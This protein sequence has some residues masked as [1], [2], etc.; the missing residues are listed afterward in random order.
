MS[1]HDAAYPESE[2]ICG[3]PLAQSKTLSAASIWQ[4]RG[5]KVCTSSPILCLRRLC[6]KSAS[7]QHDFVDITLR[8]D[9]LPCAV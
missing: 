2:P 8:R 3:S 7:R 1:A 6:F 5:S 4:N 9:Y